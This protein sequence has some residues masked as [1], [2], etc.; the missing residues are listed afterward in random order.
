MNIGCKNKIAATSVCM[1]EKGRQKKTGD[2][3]WEKLPRLSLGGLKN[4]WVAFM[5]HSTLTH[6]VRCLLL[7]RPYSHP[8]V[9]TQTSLS[10]P[11]SP[12]IPPPLGR[13][14]WYLKSL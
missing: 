8:L 2:F 9:P 10:C 6:A 3:M 11:D 4:S 7:R 12:G 1:R 13:I 5:E 14:G